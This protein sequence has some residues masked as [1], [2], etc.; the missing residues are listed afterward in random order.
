MTG[1][2]ASM[3]VLPRLLEGRLAVVTG[4][5]RGNGR[6]IA[7]GLAAA[8]AT[9][10]V[11]DVDVASAQD[12]V[13]Q[14][15]ARGGNAWAVHWDIS[16]SDHT[17]AATRMLLDRGHRVS[18]LVNNAGIEARAVAGEP[19]FVAAWQRVMSVNLEGTMRVTESLL[20]DLRA[21]R[22]SIVNIA[23]IQAF[24]AL[25]PHAAAY[26]VSKAALAQYTRALA[27]ELASDG[28]RVNALAPG[29]FDTAMTAGTRRHPELMAYFMA[30]TPMRRFGD[31]AE[32]VGPVVFLA[33]DMS[34]FVT[35]AV[36]PVDG[37]LL[38]N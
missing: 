1:G 28:V 33:S 38:A 27:I 36:L 3:P 30:R 18:V 11:C 7:L 14:V 20:G 24:V 32:L 2:A 26:S 17:E 34:T 25:Q 21:T 4:A 13:E 5:G 12:V 19:G 16:D 8:G 31:P 10:A 35:G 37:G 15:K 9:V 23:S 6:A 29:F 22:G